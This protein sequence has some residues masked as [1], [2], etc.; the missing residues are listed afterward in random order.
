MATNS[1]FARKDSALL[2]QSF[3][4]DLGGDRRYFMDRREFEDKPGLR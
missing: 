3:R 2:A 1:T 4:K